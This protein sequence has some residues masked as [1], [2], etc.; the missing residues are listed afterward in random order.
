[1]C[2][3]IQYLQLFLQKGPLWPFQMLTL[4]SSNGVHALFFLYLFFLITLRLSFHEPKDQS[5]ATSNHWLASDCCESLDEI[6]HEE[7][8]LWLLAG[9][10][11]HL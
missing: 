5:L 3:C 4:I 8:F 6:G 2:K 7:E 10:H 11:S 1:M 9:F